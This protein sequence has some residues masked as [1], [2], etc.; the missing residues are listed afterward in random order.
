MFR[1]SVIVFLFLM[2]SHAYA[3]CNASIISNCSEN[4]VDIDEDGLYD[5]LIIKVP[6]MVYE[7]DEY[8]LDAYL[9]DREDREV[10]WSID[11]QSLTEGRNEMRLVFDGKEIERSGLDGPYRLKN[12]TLTRGSSSTR[13]EICHHLPWVYTTSVYDSSEFVDPASDTRWL[14]GSG[15]GELL[16]TFG[17]NTTVPVYEGVYSYDIPNLRMPPLDSP[18][19]VKGSKTGYEYELPGITVPRKP[20]DF[21]VTVLGARDLSVGLKKLQGERTRTWVSSQVQADRDGKATITSDLIS[22]NGVYHVKIF[23]RAQDNVT[24]VQLVMTL[25]KKVVVSGRFSIGVNTSG[26]PSGDYTLDVRALNGTFRL[27]SLSYGG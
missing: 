27:D 21:T 8:S 24:A 17:V 6:V 10:A 7:P 2:A 5:L 23:G 26:L 25:V 16:I 22:P 12:L 9:Y 3:A 15:R 1:A 14:S 20:N 18:Y 4:A 19:E 11:H 13:L